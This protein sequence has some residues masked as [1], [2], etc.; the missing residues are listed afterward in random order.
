MSGTTTQVNILLHGLFFLRLNPLNNNL[1]VLAPVI[2]EHHFV[3]G[4]R[5]ARKEITDKFIDLTYL[6]GKQSDPKP[7]DIPGSVFQFVRTETDV[8]RFTGDLSQF[9][10]MI[11][12]PWPIAFYSLRCDDISKTFPYIRTKKVGI[13]IEL[14]ARR[15][16][17]S[18]LGVVTLLQ[19]TMAGLGSVQNIHYYNQPCKQH[20]IDEVNA[21]LLEAAK[22]FY[23]YDPAIPAFDLQL[24][25][26]ATII[27]TARGGNFCKNPDLG[28]TAEDEMS[29]DEDPS[30]DV[31]AICPPGPSAGFKPTGAD[32]EDAAGVSPANCPTIFVG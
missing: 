8:K 2:P 18:M 12:L 9:K 23:P 7:E 17:S 16:G 10:S 20:K 14:N 1:E 15:K 29:L 26:G 4:T 31:R 24:D 21:D 13:S 5:G 11:V 6:T 27:P 28:T 19:Y 3:G 22:C 25:P 30:P 32:D